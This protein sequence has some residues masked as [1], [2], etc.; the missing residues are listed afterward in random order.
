M[1]VPT[2]NLNGTS[3]DELLRQCTDAVQ[4]LGAAIEAMRLAWPNGRDYQTMPAGSL[5][6]A[7]SEMSARLIKL[8]DVRD[9]MRTLAWNI[10]QQ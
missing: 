10:S 1:I 3:Q 7:H 5:S 4:E 6:T 8:G 9:E 2:V